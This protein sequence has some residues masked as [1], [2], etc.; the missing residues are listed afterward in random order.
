MTKT[1]KMTNDLNFFSSN[2]KILRLNK[3][4][5]QG[6]IEGF[7]RSQWAN[8]ELGKSFPKF[9][10]LINIA[11]FF[12]ISE[13]HLIHSDLKNMEKPIVENVRSKEL[14]EE[15]R[16]LLRENRELRIEKDNLTKELATLKSF[17]PSKTSNEK[18]TKRKIG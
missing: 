13:T 17:L 10:D 6:D 14:L 2:L 9:F 16:E 18:D 3:G 5:K 12:D 8:Y 4:L 15:N 11:K 1:N 7:S